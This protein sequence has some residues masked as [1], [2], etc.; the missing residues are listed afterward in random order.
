M[1]ALLVFGLAGSTAAQSLPTTQPNYVRIIRE[2]IKLGH[3]DEHVK[4][5]AGWPAAFE[6]ANSPDFYLGLASM[7]GANEAWFLIPYESHAAMEKTF[8][9]EMGDPVLSAELSRLSRADAEHLTG[10]RTIEAMARKELS[11]GTFPKIEEQ[12]FWEVT[13][14]RVRPGHDEDFAAAAKAYGAAMMRAK[15]GNSFRVYEVLA[16]MPG[17]VYLVFSSM[18]TYGE[19]DKM[20]EGS[21]ATMKAATADERALLQKFSAEG[22]ISVESQRLRLDPQMSYVPKDVRASDPAFWIPKRSSSY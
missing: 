13:I 15:T 14:F 22:L 2:E 17:S 9:R 8:N 7:T 20:M 21:A 6:K 3:V 11:Q 1:A 4:T 5:E 16:G 19:F 10:M 18:K 12:R